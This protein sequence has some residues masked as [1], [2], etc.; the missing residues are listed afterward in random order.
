MKIRK[1]IH[2]VRDR[3]GL[4]SSLEANTFVRSVGVKLG[5]AAEIMNATGRREAVIVGEHTQIEGRLVAF[6][7]SDGI[8]IG[9]WTHIGPRSEIWSLASITIGDRVLISHDVVVNDSS[10]HSFHPAERHLHTRH[11]LTKGFPHGKVP[12]GIRFE[13]IVIEDDAWISFR[14]SILRG[15]TIGRESIIAAGSTVTRDVP[16][17]SLYRCDIR[18]IIRQ[19]TDQEIGQMNDQKSASSGSLLDKKSSELSK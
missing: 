14:V 15:V 4:R 13:P 9:E 19:L 10:G 1:L 17:R 6:P 18:P 7:Q 16:P 11:L 12:P 2:R 3:V 5:G 8:R